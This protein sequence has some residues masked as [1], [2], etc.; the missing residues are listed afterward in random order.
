MLGV[1][2]VLDNTSLQFCTCQ[3]VALFDGL[4]GH[5]MSIGDA[6]IGPQ[7][8]GRSSDAVVCVYFKVSV[9]ENE[10]SAEK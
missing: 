9:K 8:Y 1:D 5:D 4:N 2:S 3:R 10:V 7:C 6:S